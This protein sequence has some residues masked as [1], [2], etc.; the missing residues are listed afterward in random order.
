MS[1]VYAPMLGNFAKRECEIMS[2]LETTEN[3]SQAKKMDLAGPMLE[4][5]NFNTAGSNDCGHK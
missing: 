5:I 3:K 1:L 4:L 2:N